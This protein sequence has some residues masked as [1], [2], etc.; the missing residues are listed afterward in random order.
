MTAVVF[1]SIKPGQDYK[2]GVELT[3]PTSPINKNVGVFMVKR[4]LTYR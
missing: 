1:R 3:L 2:I 4:L